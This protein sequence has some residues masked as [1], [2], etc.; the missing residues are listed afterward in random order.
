[1]K[2]NSRVALTRPAAARTEAT[3][4][5][6]RILSGWSGFAEE[7]LWRSEG[8]LQFIYVLESENDF[9][10][11]PTDTAVW[12]CL[13]LRSSSPWGSTSHAICITA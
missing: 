4:R 12:S 10:A 13:L 3:A 8:E 9:G 11:Q 7:G 5:E 1:M 6:K 2:M